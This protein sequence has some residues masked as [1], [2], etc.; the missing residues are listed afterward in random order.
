VA[1]NQHFSEGV[2][3]FS[4]P[5]E[6]LIT[7]FRLAVNEDSLP[8]PWRFK[9]SPLAILHVCVQWRTLAQGDIQFWNNITVM[10]ED[11]S[12][13]VNWSMIDTTLML[14]EDKDLSL[15]LVSFIN[16]DSCLFQRLVDRL[17][18]ESS[19]IRALDVIWKYPWAP[20]PADF[21]ALYRGK[22]SQFFLKA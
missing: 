4:L 18:R 11:S 12:W 3:V 20:A 9:D 19:R 21:A 5:S 17:V 2:T 6:L 13:R 16:P 7:I 22:N 1:E 15:S 10:L 8:I 14:S